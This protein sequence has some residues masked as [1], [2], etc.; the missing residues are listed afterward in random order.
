MPAPIRPVT[1]LTLLQDDNPSTAM[2][3]M[4]VSQGPRHDM[5]LQTIKRPGHQKCT[6]HI[7]R[8]FSLF[9]HSPNGAVKQQTQMVLQKAALAEASSVSPSKS[10]T[11]LHA[12]AV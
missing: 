5:E 7:V 11:C 1:S 9:H 2:P 12:A 3:K 8:Q 6:S 4:H 10:H